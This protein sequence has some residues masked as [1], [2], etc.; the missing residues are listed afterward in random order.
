M[1]CPCRRFSTFFRFPARDPQEVEDVSGCGQRDA[2]SFPPSIH[3]F[4]KGSLSWQRIP[5]RRFTVRTTCKSTEPS[6]FAYVTVTAIFFA[7]RSSVPLPLPQPQALTRCILQAVASVS[8]R[9][10]DVSPLWVQCPGQ[11]GSRVLKAPQGPLFPPQGPPP[12][13]WTHWCSLQPQGL[14]SAARL[15]T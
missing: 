2:P 11:V 15:S 3:S 4:E 14:D 1:H 5:K 7:G 12:A 6:G 10:R 9:S 13:P 8:P